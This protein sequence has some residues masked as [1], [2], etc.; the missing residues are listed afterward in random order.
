MMTGSLGLIA[1]FFKHTIGA[2]GFYAYQNATD[3]PVCKNGIT[4]PPR[5]TLVLVSDDP[6]GV[7]KA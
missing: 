4:V 5:T 2:Q 1:R 7:P 6:A 3:Y